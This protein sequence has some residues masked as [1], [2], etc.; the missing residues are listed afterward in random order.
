MARLRSWPWQ[1][2]GL[3]V[4]GVVEVDNLGAERLVLALQLGVLVTQVVDFAHRGVV[5]FPQLGILGLQQAVFAIGDTRTAEQHAQAHYYNILFHDIVF[6][7][8]FN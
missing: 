1:G 5:V 2:L 6:V 8:V 3:L 7:L 4:L